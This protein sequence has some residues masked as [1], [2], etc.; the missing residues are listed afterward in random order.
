MA[1]YTDMKTLLINFENRVIKQLHQ[2]LSAQLTKL[3]NVNGEGFIFR[4]SSGDFYT[5]EI[6]TYNNGTLTINVK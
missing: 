5:E 4:D 6:F 2:P 1:D 3:S